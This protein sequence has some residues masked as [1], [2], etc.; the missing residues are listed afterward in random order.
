MN[1]EQAQELWALELESGKHKQGTGRLQSEDFY[2]CLGIAC[3]VAEKHGIK[4]FRDK[5]NCLLGKTLGHQKNVQEWLGITSTNGHYGYTNKMS[6]TL[7]ND[8]ER[9]TLPQIAAVIRSKPKGLFV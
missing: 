2:C 1:N 3:L 4:V 8:E 5:D 9:K 7:L 6:V